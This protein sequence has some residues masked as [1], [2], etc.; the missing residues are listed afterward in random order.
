MRITF[1]LFAVVAPFTLATSMALPAQARANPTSFSSQSATQDHRTERLDLRVGQRLNLEGGGSLILRRGGV[2][3]IIGMNGLVARSFRDATIVQD[4]SGVVWII[5]SGQRVRAGVPSEVVTRDHRTTVVTRDH[6]TTP[7]EVL[8]PTDKPLDL[9]LGQRFNLEGGGSLI[10]RPGGVL[11]IIGMN[12]LVARSFRDATIVEDESGVVWIISSGQRV[13]AGVPSRIVTRDHRTT[14]ETRDHRTTAPEV[15]APTDKP[16]DLRLGQRFNLDGGGSLIL[17]RG[18]VLEFINMNG[19]VARS[20]R[21]ATIVEDESGVVWIISSGQ[22]VRAGVPSRGVTRDHRTTAPEVLAPTDKPVDLRLGQRFNLE[23]G[24][25]L[26]LRRGGVLEIIGMNGLV[27]SSFRDATVV[28]DESGTVWIISSGQRVR[29]GVA[30]EGVV[31]PH[32]RELLEQSPAFGGPIPPSDSSGSATQDHRTRRL[33]LRLGQ[34]LNLEGGSSLILRPGGVLEYITMNGLV[35][36]SF[37]DATIVEDGSGVVWI[38][39]S[40]SA[41][42]PAKCIPWT[43]LC[44]VTERPVEAGVLQR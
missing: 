28:E 20:F 41:F 18:G 29:A 9:R 39:L 13:R 5:S 3:E 22:R 35:A 33:D 4:Q 10:L 31:R 24:G 27:A 7:P 32:V 25:S 37:R 43:V 1:R 17:R 38:V 36:R 23:G 19:L 42:D 26:I 34:R 21:D 2:L 16:V 8:A 40:A 14:G 44:E 30:S 15:L 12:G 6:R 11:E